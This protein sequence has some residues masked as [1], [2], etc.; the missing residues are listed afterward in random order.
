MKPLFKRILG[1]WKLIVLFLFIFI[2]FSYAM[3]QG[4]FV[5]WFLFYSFLPFAIYAVMISFY[6]LQSFSV[7]RTFQKKEYNAG[8]MLK[9]QLTIKKRSA[10][11]LLYLVIE[12]CLDKQ[13]INSQQRIGDAKILLFPGFRKE[14]SW[15][16]EVTHLRRGEH[17]FR[18]IRLKIGD[19]LGLIEKEKRIPAHNKIIVYPSY[20]ELIYRPH[21]GQYEEGM[22]ASKERVQRD[23]SMAIGIRNYQ[24][25]DKFS[26]INW[27]ATAKRNDMMTKEFEQR[28]SH[29]V[30]IFM[31]CTSNSRFEAIVS[32]TASLVRAVIRKG[33]QIGFFANSSERISI[34]IRGGESQQQIIFHQLA[35]VRDDSQIAFER[36]IQV[37]GASVMQGNNV[38]IMTAELTSPLIESVGRLA[39][40]KGAC[41]IYLLKNERE[42]LTE[43]ERALTAAAN[44]RGLRV[45]L[46]HDG[47][48]SAVFSQEVANR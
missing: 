25:G 20:E 10:F 3:F 42:S 14:I 22:T 35:K 43:A 34:P 24:P 45:V 21:V 11:P 1:V 27:K 13:L 26:W 16:Y 15:N 44:V 29:D 7:E 4:G 28:Q 17:F 6:P 2:T 19:P 46:V 5:S 36:I 38:M 41:T 37:E 39:S 9:V 12:D 8:E 18:E 31:D 32:F 40:G 30:Y 47:H 48:F 23:T 33:A